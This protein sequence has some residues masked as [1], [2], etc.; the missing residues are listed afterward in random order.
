MKTGWYNLPE[1]RVYYEENGKMV[2]GE[3]KINNQWYMFDKI[4]GAMKT[5]FYKHPNKTVYYNS[6]GQMLYGKQ[7][8]N[9]KIYFFNKNIF[10]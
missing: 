6:K 4:T 8:I 1:K 5:G 10:F 3:K 2:H 9:G 7:I